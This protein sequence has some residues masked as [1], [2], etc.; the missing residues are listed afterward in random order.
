[1]AIVG[2]GLTLQGIKAEFF[3]ALSDIQ[4]QTH[5]EDWCTRLRSTSQT[6]RYRFLG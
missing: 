5:Y 4:Q 2:T 3:Q 1:M 6:E